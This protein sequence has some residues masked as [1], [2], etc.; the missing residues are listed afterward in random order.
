MS[1][2]NSNQ[3]Y[4]YPSSYGSQAFG[5]MGAVHPHQHQ[6]SHPHPHPH[7][8]PHQH[9]HSHAH[10]NHPPPSTTP[11]A[12]AALANNYYSM[13]AAAIAARQLYAQ[14]L[15]QAHLQAQVAQY[16]KQYAA[17]LVNNTT[18][19]VIEDNILHDIKAKTHSS[20]NPGPSFV[21]EYKSKFAEESEPK[22]KVQGNTI[23]FHF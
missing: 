15:A 20:N 22:H 21:D 2:Y 12:S 6:H 14:K 18:P 19:N 7:P 11:P 13:Q 10:P 5:S 17:N 1:F 3:F 8:H 4:Q 16:A 9:Q 23:H